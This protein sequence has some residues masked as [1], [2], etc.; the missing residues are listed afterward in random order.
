MVQVYQRVIAG[1]VGSTPLLVASVRATRGGHRWTGEVR[2]PGFDE[3]A[4]TT[5]LFAIVQ[6]GYVPLR[7]MAQSGE[8]PEILAPGP[9]PLPPPAARMEL[10][11]RVQWPDPVVTTVDQ[12]L[13]NGQ[14]E[15]IVQNAVRLIDRGEL[16]KARILLQ[17][18]IERRPTTDA[19]YVEL[20]RVA[21]KSNWSPQGRREAEALI[22]SAL[23]ISPNSANAKILL[24]YVLA[25]EGR[26]K[27]AEPLFVQVA[28][29]NPPN[30]YLWANWGEMLVM[31]N[32]KDA[33][34]AKYREAVIRPP[35]RDTYDRA[36][37]DAFTNLLQLLEERQDLAGMESMYRQRAAE[38]PDAD[39]F[40][41]DYAR[42]L[43]LQRSDPEGAAA[44]LRVSPA[45]E[46][47]ADRTREVQG[48]VHYVNWSRSTDTAR[49]E[50]LLRARAFLPAGPRLF[51]ALASNDRTAAIAQQLIANGDALDAQDFRGYDALGYALTAGEV[52]VTRRLLR[53]GAKPLAAIGPERMPAAL[54][55]VLSGDLESIRVLQR[56]GVDYA[57]LS[58]K[59]MTAIDHARNIGD[60]KLLLLLNQ[61]AG[62]V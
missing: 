27:E 42:F 22:R 31:Q 34:I 6:G 17:L 11:K 58:F 33:A 3:L 49:V 20:A 46:C 24:G 28:P 5:Q 51:Y 15:T 60:K 10:N 53:L 50:L 62:A 14:A 57:K 18:L 54:I 48:L 32:K 59:G 35:T 61:K 1:S 56:A 52:A 40:G 38:Y 25:H 44:A 43:V 8:V 23:Q 19:A 37:Q 21:M 55:P 12:A 26:F 13:A 41:P 2:N 45:P 9:G 4:V 36:R 30:L 16:P 29:S 7:P 47:A 39:C